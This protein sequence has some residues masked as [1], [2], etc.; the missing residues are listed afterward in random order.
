[1]SPDAKRVI[2]RLDAA[3]ERWWLFTLLSTAVLGV[4][5]SMGL[6]LLCMLGDA[7]ARLPQAGLWTL[8]LIWLGV[9]LAVGLG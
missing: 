4:C 7:L 6:L 1:M 5:A 9:T 2:E 3:R 8:F